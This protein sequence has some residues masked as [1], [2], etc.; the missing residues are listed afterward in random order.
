L[1][2][3]VSTGDLILHGGQSF[4]PKLGQNF[5]ATKFCPWSEIAQ[6]HRNNLSVSMMQPETGLGTAIDIEA[7]E[8][9][10]YE[11]QASQRN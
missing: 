10:K 2:L 1:S 5:G 3:A 9:R 8:R 6:K 7:A 11:D 4:N